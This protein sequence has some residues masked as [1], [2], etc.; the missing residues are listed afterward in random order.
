MYIIPIQRLTVRRPIKIDIRS[1]SVRVDED[2]DRAGWRGVEGADGG[3]VA[4]L[5]VLGRD[6]DVE[7]GI[8]HRVE[9]E[10]LRGKDAR[11]RAGG[12]ELSPEVVAAR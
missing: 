9:G 2:S 12:G 7:E 10:L 1:I 11:R 4:D 3:E 8:A 5:G 6:L